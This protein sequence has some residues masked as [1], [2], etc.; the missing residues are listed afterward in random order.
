MAW[1]F[2]AGTA[3]S[4]PHGGYVLWVQLP[5]GCIDTLELMRRALDEGVSLAPGALFSPNGRHGGDMRLNFGHP[6]SAEME[7]GVAVIGRLAGS[8]A[9]AALLT[10]PHGGGRSPRV[11]PGR[12]NRRARSRR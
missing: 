1:H 8:A 3:A 6:W 9:P 2:P 7:R 12:C 5:A 11:Q 4:R 10:G